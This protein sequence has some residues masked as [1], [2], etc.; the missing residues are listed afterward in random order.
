MQIVGSRPMRIR[1]T[2]VSLSIALGYAQNPQGTDQAGKLTVEVGG[3]QVGA[4]NTLNFVSGNGILEACVDNAGANR[5][6]CTPSYN[7]A[8]VP[9]HDT[10]YANEN[11]CYSSNGTTLY[12]CHL[13]FRALK[14]YRPGMTFLLNVDASCASSCS[15]NV[16]DVGIV[17]IKKNDGTTDPA[18]SLVAGQPQWIFF[19]GT[20]FRLIAS[21]STGSTGRAGDHDRDFIGRRFISAMDTMTYAPS[22]SLEVTAGDV[23]KTITSNSVGDATINAVTAGLAGQH[24]WIIVANDLVR[25]KTIA[26][27]A[28]FKSAGTLAGSPGKSATVHF[29]S[30]GTAWYEVARTLNL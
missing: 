18:G 2:L 26:F 24:M 20:V 3:A 14:A 11:Y 12:T 30:D 10:I 13:P 7:Y 23:H 1:I 8:V 16:D 5:I 6:D 28:N 27:G 9:T 21:A 19:D 22:I 15:V 25:G 29:I 4:R 17:T